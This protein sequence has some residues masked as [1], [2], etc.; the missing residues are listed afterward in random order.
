MVRLAAG[1]P[2]LGGELSVFSRHR[3]QGEGQA[4]SVVWVAGLPA[5]LS[6]VTVFS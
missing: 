4:V 5:L 6:P 3:R 1:W 2:G